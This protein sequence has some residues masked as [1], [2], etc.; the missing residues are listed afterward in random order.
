MISLL[1]RMSLTR[2]VPCS[3]RV[4]AAWRL[5]KRVVVGKHMATL[6][7]VRLPIRGKVLLNFFISILSAAKGRAYFHKAQPLDC[8]SQK[9]RVRNGCG[10]IP[11]VDE[12]AHLHCIHLRWIST[13]VVLCSGL[14]WDVESHL[15]LLE[16]ETCFEL[17]V[18]AAKIK[19]T[20]V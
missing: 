15:C 3:L 13:N 19:R 10:S 6:V 8:K 11:W 7:E 16:L 12:K 18:S 14:S 5:K 9:R 1:H 17:S 4:T 2:G 20:G